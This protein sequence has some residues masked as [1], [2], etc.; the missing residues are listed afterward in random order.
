MLS[1]AISKALRGRATPLLGR[2]VADVAGIAYKA[3]IDALCRMPDAGTLVRF[4]R[5]YRTCGRF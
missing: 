1:D 4:G 3:A 2:E 5:K